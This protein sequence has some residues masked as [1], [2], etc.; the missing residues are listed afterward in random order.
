M[1]STKT[2]VCP[3]CGKE[4]TNKGIGTHIWR[5]HGSGIN[6]K[7]NNENRVAWNKGL[8]KLTDERIAKQ[9]KKLKKNRPSYQI[10][11]DDDGKMYQR[12]A[13]KRINAKREG[14]KFELTFEEFCLIC[15][16]CNLKS[17]NLGFSG[18]GFVLARYNDEGGY[19][20][21]NCRFITQLENVHERDKHL[22]FVKTKCIEDNIC[23]NS[24]VAAANYYN[25]HKDTLRDSLSHGK[26]YVSSINKTF[27]RIQ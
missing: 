10:K 12:Y 20:Y 4:Y 22:V 19:S 8:T 16:E 3:Y 2:K 13:N 25:I 9:A 24:I 15:D 17:S 5:N 23:F 11:V 26:G 14:I 21:G 7:S 27:E 6:F 18:D 1:N